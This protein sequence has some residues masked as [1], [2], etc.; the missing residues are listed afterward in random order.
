MRQVGRVW[1]SN[2]I[3]N[4]IQEVYFEIVK[5]IYQMSLTLQG[6]QI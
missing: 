1:E 5:K 2:E 4:E 6:K 3:N